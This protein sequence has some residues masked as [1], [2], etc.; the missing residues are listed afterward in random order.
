M[1]QND[2]YIPVGDISL[3]A[4][5]LAVGIPL[6]EE[7]PCYALKQPGGNTHYQFLFQEYSLCENYKTLTLINAWEN[8]SWHISNPEHSFAYIKC[9]FKNKESLLDKVKQGSE[10]VMIEKNGKIAV[11][12]KNASKDLQDKIFGEM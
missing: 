10:L 6:N 11:L 7:T 2:A 8:D 1:K 9:A 12:S 3:A 5:L 4:A